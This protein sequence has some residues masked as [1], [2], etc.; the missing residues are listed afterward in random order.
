MWIDIGV[1]ETSI[2]NRSSLGEDI[3]IYCEKPM[4]RVHTSFIESL[5][6]SWLWE[7]I[8]YG[9]VSMVRIFDAVRQP[10]STMLEKHPSKAKTGEGYGEI[11]RA[12]V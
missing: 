6:F 1:A 7:I 11:G 2:I 4:V 12:H 3:T 9:R 10:S 5:G 8:R